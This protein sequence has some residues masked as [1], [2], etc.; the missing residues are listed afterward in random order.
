MAL[1]RGFARAPM[2][3]LVAALVAL[4]VAAAGLLT[5]PPTAHAAAARNAEDLLV[6]DCLLPGQIRKLGRQANFMSARRPIRT[7]QADCEI[8]GGEYAAYDR[9][10]YQTALGVWM[11]QAVAG[12]AQ[13]QNYVGEIYAK[14][15][16]TAPDHAMAASWFRKAAEQ[17]DKR[18]R[19]NLGYLYEQGL[20]V[21]KNLGEALNLYRAA[22]GITG[23]ELVFASTVQVQL[24]ARD[25]QISGLRQTVEQQAQES[26]DLRAENEQLR[27]Q[28]GERRRA[29]ETAQLE[30]QQT[31]ARLDDVRAATG[32][33]LGELDRLRA[34]LNARSAD[35]DGESARLRA[36]QQESAL[37][38]QRAE[39][40]L[41][42][43]RQR[44]A[45]LAGS[46][47]PAADSQA[48]LADIRAQTSQLSEA[49]AAAQQSAATLQQQL[50]A[51]QALLD[52]QR[53]AYQ[54]EIDRLQ[55]QSD[56]R[57]QEDWQ[58]MKLLENQLT[59]KESEI[60]EQQERI[61]SLERRIGTGTLAAG[62]SLAGT[63]PTLEIIDPPITA[64]RGRPAAVLRSAPGLHE[65]VGKVSA[66]QGIDR[67][68]LNGAPADL[69]ASGVFRGRVDVAAG[70]TVVQVAAVDAR[71]ASA[72][73]EFMIVPQAAGAPAPAA[74]AGA[75]AGSVP[76][77]VDLGTFHALVIG[78]NTYQTSSYPA[79][80]SAVNDATA[81]A[82]TLKQRYG[83]RTTLLLNA[84]RL[85]ILTALNTLRE[86][87]TA[88]DNLLVYY[89][90]HGE[91]GSDGDQ[92]YWIPVDGQPSAPQ[93]WISNAAISAILDT[94]RARHV[95]VVADSCYAGA[96]TRS[97]VATFDNTVMPDDAWAAWVK[98]MAGG[99]SRTA[100]T[101]G[102]VQPVPDTGSGKHSYFARAFLNVLEDNNRLLEAQRLF[103]EINTALALSAIDSPVPQS[104]EYS[105]I[106]YAGHESGEFFF[107]PRDR[108]VAVASR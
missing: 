51:N 6:V 60:R 55:A 43:L 86:D 102:G 107:L 42:E 103:R 78:N 76:D 83:Y 30:L 32:A 59:A 93:T 34:D 26:A 64:T 104:P 9:A 14:G 57:K 75:P 56:G 12:N 45:A 63:L 105:P 94:M 35:I 40:R 33:D 67:I 18:A 11:D 66:P 77:G 62:G 22:S 49:V 88:D 70:G 17:G 87:L 47:T 16:G 13:A 25:R 79:L 31:R 53:A 84:T 39:Q 50:A 54:A 37:R 97:A 61:A 5:V 73:L 2:R 38:A 28:L 96:M 46:T 58:L 81:V 4:P 8:R 108:R 27:R 1:K 91:L 74:S 15:L 44:E 100:L 98:A 7:V 36:Q 95:L 52:R 29:L 23:D 41:T 85:D 99:R 65:V 82:Q 106:R 71:G 69:A 20:G 68:T 90:G 24:E 3:V 10:N 92:G 89:A 72:E 21:E 48:M 80:A 101:S 19:I